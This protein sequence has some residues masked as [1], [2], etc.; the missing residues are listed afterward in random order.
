[1]RILTVTHYMPPHLGGIEM[2]ADALVRGLAAR[3]HD[4]RW[5]AS[6][7]PAR[8]GWDGSRLRVPAWNALEARAGLPYPLW[9]ARGLRDLDR[10]VTLADVVHVHDCL[11]MGSAA[12]VA[13][14]R[15]LGKPVLLTQHIGMVPYGP[16]LDRV[17]RLAYAT[18][19]RAVLAG[20]DKLVACA[21]HVPAFFAELGVAR[22]FE[23]I[24]NGIDA[25]RFVGASRERRAAL[26]A[27]YD[28]SPTARVV[29]FSGRL[30]AKKGV[31][32]V[33]TLQRALAADTPGSELFVAGDGPLAHLLHGSPRTRRLGVVSPAQMPELYALADLMVLPSHGEG[34]P[35]GVQEAMLSG[36]SVVVSDDPAFRDGLTGMPGVRFARTAEE[37]LAASRL[38]LAS[39]TPRAW[40]REA[41]AA[42]W[43]LEPF[44]DAYER[45]LAS[46]LK[47]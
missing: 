45:A 47:E 38:T 14:A 43:G 30:V 6:A 33:A 20:A 31:D 22:P 34:L 17:E 16:V 8:P 29:L 18:L 26:R 28:L 5:V 40:V 21:P 41:A 23:L 12:A 37:L 27:R 39:P 24:R 36:A 4:T 42:R 11:Y 3:G 44:L 13:S 1:M 15:R 19:G 35:L 2:V 10:Q 32:K 46:L 9:A 25:E 7:V